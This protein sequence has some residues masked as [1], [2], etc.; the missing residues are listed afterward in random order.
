M[1]RASLTY[2]GSIGALGVALAVAL[3]L[4]LTT[5]AD[6]QTQSFQAQYGEPVAPSGP[7]AGAECTSI[8]S[9]DGLLNAGDS[10]SF[11]SGF[12]VA[13]GASLVLEDADGTQGTLIDKENAEISAGENGNIELLLTRPPLN[14]VGGDGVVGSDVCD[15]LVTTTGISALQ[16][17]GSAD[18]GAATASGSASL[19]GVLPS[20]G[21]SM[22]LILLAGLGA[23]GAGLAVAVYRLRPRG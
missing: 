12:S 23:V 5:A 15:E 3:A 16:G 9:E 11:G 18:S 1:R 7:A 20:T 17:V 6:A 13:P 8:Q 19:F 14:V 22:L 21:G 10:V 4:I 2:T